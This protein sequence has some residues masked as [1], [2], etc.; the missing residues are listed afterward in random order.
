M[1]MYMCVCVYVC[2]CVSHVWERERYC[3]KAAVPLKPVFLHLK[4]ICVIVQC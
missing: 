4:V 3:Y 1:Y 2:V